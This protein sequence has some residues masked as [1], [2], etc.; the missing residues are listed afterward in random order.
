MPVPRTT[1]T[2]RCLANIA[3]PP[4]RRLTT[5]SFQ[6]RSLS[7]SICGSAKD[8]P[9]SAISFVS[10][11]TFAACSSALDG[12]QPMLRQTPPSLSP[13][14]TRTTLLPRSA[15]RNAALY[16]PGPA[17]STSTSRMNV[18]PLGHRWPGRWR[19]CGCRRLLLGGRCFTGSQFQDGVLGGHGIADLHLD[20]D[21]GASRWGGHV[22]GGLVG[23]Q[24]DQRVV[25]RDGVA[26]TDMHLDDW[27]RIEVTNVGDATSILS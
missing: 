21:D 1:S 25:D 13:R 11:I 27:Y 17:P 6:S 26:D 8:S 19:W 10:A 9:Y 14:S 7:M 15:A 12:M 22:H 18:A 23:L 5:L 3:R 2:L 4:V 20:R 24:R 16:P